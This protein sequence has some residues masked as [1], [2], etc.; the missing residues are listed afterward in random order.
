MKNLLSW[1]KRVS[2]IGFGLIILCFMLFAPPAEAL[3][4][5]KDSEGLDYISLFQEAFLDYEKGSYEEARDKLKECLTQDFEKGKEVRVLL[6]KTYFSM[7]EYKDVLKCFKD[8]EIETYPEDILIQVHIIK[9]KAF[10]MREKTKEAVEE[11]KKVLT[12]NSSEPESNFYM[13]LISM[14]KEHF[15]SAVQFY[16]QARAEGFLLDNLTY[17]LG[18]SYYMTGEYFKAIE[19]LNKL[20]RNF[21]DNKQID[22]FLT[23]ALLKIG[24]LDE[25]FEK[26][27]I[28]KEDVESSE[29]NQIAVEIF[30]HSVENKNISLAKRMLE[31][32]DMQELSGK[33][34]FS[35]NLIQ[36]Y[37]LSDNKGLALDEL[38]SLRIENPDAARYA[39]STLFED[40]LIAK[41]SQ[42]NKFKGLLGLLLSAGVLA[43]VYLFKKKKEKGEITH[44]L[45]VILMCS[46]LLILLLLAVFGF[47]SEGI[48]VCG[49]DHIT[50]RGLAYVNSISDKAL[51]SFVNVS[52]F[53]GLLD[54]IE[55]SGWSLVANIELGDF[56]QPI[57]DIVNVLWKTLLICT[58]VLL[59]FKFLFSIVN[60]VG[61]VCIVPII[62]FS[63]L[64][65]L[66]SE[67]N[68]GN[69]KLFL[70]LKRIRI[71]F[72]LI[73]TLLV[74]IFPLSM[75]GSSF[76][77]DK[78]IEQKIKLSADNLSSYNDELQKEVLQVQDLYREMN[79]SEE[80]DDDKNES[81]RFNG[82]ERIK[83][84]N[85][86]LDTVKGF[87]SSE[88]VKSLLVLCVLFIFDVIVFPIVLL[89][90]LILFVKY[91]YH[92]YS[93]KESDL[94][95]AFKKSEEEFCQ[96]FSED[97]KTYYDKKKRFSI[98]VGIQKLKKFFSTREDEQ[99]SENPS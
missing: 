4:S 35:V 42:E 66:L 30:K 73:F 55:G 45:Y 75:Y 46:L 25:A 31:D 41:D 36:Y 11:F 38:E 62:V 84:L 64:I 93:D 78:L 91:I 65:F 27:Q 7:K 29:L 2:F 92:I 88:K 9:G 18:F 72:L 71:I 19:E 61:N 20:D 82:R 85:N 67:Y 23:I 16:L 97:T 69:L 13:G 51:H 94:I 56:A 1:Q 60:Y 52:V 47:V 58:S 77:S 40:D 21:G 22:K 15:L 49:I 17:N 53:K 14:K 86:W 79:L 8:E 43:A 74:F 57:I 50:N 99:D 76:V 70:V 34:G 98:K 32:V 12:I 33:P 54:I 37:L 6:A 63:I 89:A 39:E 24:H 3:F 90:L 48:R 83:K 96:D 68:K 5:S 10:Y 59:S 81:D 80:K 28:L 95:V 26:Y 44:K 87:F